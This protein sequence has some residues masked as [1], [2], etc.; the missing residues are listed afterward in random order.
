MMRDRTQAMLLVAARAMLGLMNVTSEV[1]EST[2]RAG[3]AHVEA[4]YPLERVVDMWEALY[5]ELVQRKGVT[6]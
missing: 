5:Q 3:R 2:G 6:V 4:S 1:R